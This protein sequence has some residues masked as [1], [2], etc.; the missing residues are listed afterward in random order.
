MFSK[1]YKRGVQNKRKNSGS[2][3]QTFHNLQRVCETA[4][5]LLKNV[6]AVLFFRC[7]KKIVDSY[8]IRLRIYEHDTYLQ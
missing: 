4:I 5:K 7:K 3:V 8:F 2:V 6:F 1:T